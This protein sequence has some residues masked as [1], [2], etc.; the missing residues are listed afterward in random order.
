VLDACA[1]VASAIL[2]RPG[3]V[4][5]VATSREPLG[6]EG[7][8]VFRVP[9]LAIPEDAADATRGEAVRLFVERATAVDAGFALTP[10]VAPVVVEIC[11]R[12]DGIPLAIE[13][14]A[15]RV[16]HLSPDEIARRLDDRFRLLT[17]GP[18]GAR[19]RQQTLAAALD[20]SHQL[21]AERER[22]LLRRCAVFVDG[23]SLAAAEGVCAGDGL[24]RDDVVDVL[25]ALVD[26]SLVALHAAEH[27]Y[28]LLETIRLYAEER[29]IEAGEAD[30]IR[31]RQVS[32]F[33]KEYDTS[34]LDTTAVSAADAGNLR[35][36][37]VWAD[38]TRNGTA[39]ARL[40]VALFRV[41]SAWDPA[42]REQRT[43]CESALA[44]DDLPP[45]VR[46]ETLAV[47]SFLAITAGDWSAAVELGREAI[48]VAPDPGEGF[49]SCAYVPVAIG[50]MV[51]DQ[52]AADRLINEGV[53]RIRRSRAPFYPAAVLDSFRIGTALM[54]GD[55]AAAAE[56]APTI[57]AF[58]GPRA[59]VLG[60]AFA[61]HLL[62]DH[63]AAEHEARRHTDLSMSGAGHHARHLLLA[64]TATACGRR[65]DARRELDAAV[66]I[67][68][69]YRHPLTLNDCTV[70]CGA[71]AVMEGRLERA[72][73]LLAAVADR[74]AVRSP[75]F[76]AIYLHYRRS[77]RA[78][79]D[80]ET[81]RRCREEARS[82]DLE[83]A[84]DEELSRH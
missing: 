33:E 66:A 30:A 42:W 44:Y 28:R 2:A 5:I 50:L 29:L 14:A 10:A 51:H 41:N 63:D 84:I 27:R 75:E 74:S 43:W 80:A 13:L 22:T 76:W 11:R 18:R 77:V 20:W 3:G 55:A 71:I 49:A 62:G 82:L 57:D 67:A 16:R 39:V 25:G 24:E 59:M 23:F 83:R 79:L 26:K 46:A 17:G 78:A 61:L 12:L 9:S 69:R 53:E 34:Q 32:W 35:A 65:D 15:A 36:A 68:R 64:L 58:T 37:R 19:Q 38:E 70:V 48:A 21:L 45:V 81:I 73:V 7:E 8:Q 56:I 54:R 31:T 6:V 4:A 1:E 40:T 72:S 52:D 47:A 60:L